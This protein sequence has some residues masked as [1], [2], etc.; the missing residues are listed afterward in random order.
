MRNLKTTLA[1]ATGLALSLAACGNDPDNADTLDT[2]TGVTDTTMADSTV[3]SDEF[4]P[5]ERDY[6][7]TAEAQE[8]RAEFD[9][10]EFNNEFR[11][12]HDGLAQSGS[13]TTSGGT[14]TT[15]SPGTTTTTGQMGS[16]S[17]MMDRSAMNWSYLDR[18]SDGRLSVA[19]YAI[20]AIPMDPTAPKPNDE[21]AP[22]TTAEQANRAADSFFYYD[23]DGDSYLSQIEFN[24]ARRG[25]DVG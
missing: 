15:T 14:T 17:G 21:N 25:G 18:N 1:A 7:L 5:L 9:M 23:A 6:T 13:A 12:I 4:N 20:W 8:R 19:E 11:E 3:N 2:D 16:G 22:Y 10:D 24:N